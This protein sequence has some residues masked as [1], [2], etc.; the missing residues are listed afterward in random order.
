MR[1]MACVMLIL[2]FALRNTLQYKPIFG[3]GGKG[4]A[5]AVIL[6]DAQTPKTEGNIVCF[7]VKIEVFLSYFNKRT[8]Q[9]EY[10]SNGQ[11]HTENSHTIHRHVFPFLP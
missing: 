11:S 5:R 9:T 2:N 3:G 1:L 6:S 4:V 8:L 7:P 10:A